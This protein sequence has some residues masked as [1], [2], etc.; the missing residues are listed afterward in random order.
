MTYL[1]ITS[2]TGTGSG[3]ARL[4]SANGTTF[5]AGNKVD[6]AVDEDLHGTGVCSVASGVI[7][8]PVG[9]YYLLEGSVGVI[10]VATAGANADIKHRFYDEN[11]SADI[12]TE[13]F[14]IAYRTNAGEQFQAFS[15]DD[16]ARCWVD[17]TSTAGSI[18]LRQVGTSA[19]DTADSTGFG[20]RR[21]TGFSRCLVWRFE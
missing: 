14:L 20:G 19:F 4:R 17:A 18:S 12:G 1:N 16:M 7:T 13:A 11:A 6:W 3:L 5:G 2:Q 9:S 21:W 15:Q 10:D 8:L